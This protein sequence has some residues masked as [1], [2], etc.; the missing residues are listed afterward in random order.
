[1]IYLRVLNL[2]TFHLARRGEIL[3]AERVGEESRSASPSANPAKAPSNPERRFHTV[4]VA[5]DRRAEESIGNLSRFFRVL[6][7]LQGSD[8]RALLFGLFTLSFGALLV[9]SPIVAT[10]Y[11][12]VT[13]VTDPMSCAQLDHTGLM[14]AQFVILLALIVGG[15][16]LWRSLGKAHAFRTCLALTVLLGAG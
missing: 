3:A 12:F 16:F 10:A 11:G 7:G 9:V 13:G 15:F 1:M 6:P 5:L 4:R 2:V 14:V 8:K